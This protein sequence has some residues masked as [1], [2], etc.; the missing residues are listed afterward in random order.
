VTNAGY[1][2]DCTVPVSA[3]TTVLLVGGDGSGV[4]SGGAETITVKESGDQ[5]CLGPSSPSSTSGPPAGSSQMGSSTVYST[6]SSSGGTGGSGSTTGS[7]SKSDKVAII[8][9]AAAGGGLIIIA[10]NVLLCTCFIRRR[11]RTR[12]DS[13]IDYLPD[14]IEPASL[15]QLPHSYQQETFQSSPRTTVFSQGQQSYDPHRLTDGS[16][17]TPS[18]TRTGLDVTGAMS[19]AYGIQSYNP[20]QS[21]QMD[22]RMTSL[23][24]SGSPELGGPYWG[25]TSSSSSPRQNSSP[26]LGQMP[27]PVHHVIHQDDAG[28][29]NERS[30]FPEPL[31]FPP[32]YSNIW[33]TLPQ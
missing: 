20:Y 19:S 15:N 22:S 23:Q 2:F 3:G 18:P 12:Y 16:T 14:N 4:A 7:P 9:G 21:M 25:S 26:V 1:G 17:T 13:T 27:Y 6:S 33:N 11:Q 24:Q 29:V 8:G 10:I 30:Y 28:T 31:E 5:S 32:A